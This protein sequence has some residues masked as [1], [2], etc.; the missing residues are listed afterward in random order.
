MSFPSVV[1]LSLSVLA[2]ALMSASVLAFTNPTEVPAQSSAL[3][4]RQPLITTARAGERVVAAGGRGHIVYS[5][6]EGRN[7]LQAKVPVSIDLVALSFPLAGSGWAVGHSGVVLHTSDSG[8]TWAKQLDGPRAVSIATKFYAEGEQTEVRRV[9]LG[10]LEQLQSFEASQAFLDVFFL[11]DKEGFVVGT[12]NRIFHT[13]DGGETWTPLMHLTGNDREL[14]FYS[15]RGD[16]RAVWVTGEQGAVWKLNPSTL[17]FQARPTPYGG[18]LFGSIVKDAEVLVYG[19]RGSL[20]SSVDDGQTWKKVDVPNPAG[21]TG[22]VVLDDGRCLF[23]TQGGAA[24]IYGGRDQPVREVTLP[25]P[26]AYFGVGPAAA[27]K[28]AVVGAEG[29]RVE[30]LP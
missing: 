6:D 27:G 28:V 11:D 19:M 3:A 9:A 14:H 18:T 7:W 15:L 30:T 8:V 24:F 4:A 16:R 21:I 1:A 22:G 17:E 25:R 29:V 13:R 20:F 26:M 5:D 2:S 23:V 12:F 10:K